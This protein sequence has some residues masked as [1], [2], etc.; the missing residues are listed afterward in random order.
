MNAVPRR[1]WQVAGALCIAHV[2]LIPVCLVLQQGRC[3]P[4]APRAS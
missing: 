1:L 2:A 3:S 4:T